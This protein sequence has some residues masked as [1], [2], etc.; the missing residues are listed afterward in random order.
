MFMSDRAKEVFLANL[1]SNKGIIRAL[2][3]GMNSV[4]HGQHSV[5]QRIVTLQEQNA[6]YERFLSQAG[7]GQ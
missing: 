5:N 2:E 1:I 6:Q 4:G 3:S 7:F